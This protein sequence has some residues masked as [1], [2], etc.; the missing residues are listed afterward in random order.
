MLQEI[1]TSYRNNFT[2]HWI[3]EN[4]SITWVS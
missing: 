3:T 2:E 4:A 1:A